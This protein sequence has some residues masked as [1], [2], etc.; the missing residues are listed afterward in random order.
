MTPPKR[1]GGPD[2]G[3]GGGNILGEVLTRPDAAVFAIDTSKDDQ[4]LGPLR[5]GLAR[6]DTDPKAAVQLLRAI[7]AAI[8]QRTK[9]LAQHGHSKWEQGCGLTYWV[10]WI[11]EAAKVMNGLSSKD[12]ERLEELVKEARSAGV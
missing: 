10:L 3:G 8:P 11:E 1:G 5:P 12:E 4:T 6:F 2:S 9:W 7:H